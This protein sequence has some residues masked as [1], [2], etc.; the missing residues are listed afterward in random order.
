M[1]EKST[2]R[3]P[4]TPLH[5][6]N[7][8]GTA[9]RDA[10]QLRCVADDKTGDVCGRKHLRTGTT[11]AAEIRSLPPPPLPRVSLHLGQFC[12]ALWSELL[13]WRGEIASPQ[14]ARLIREQVPDFLS[15]LGGQR[16]RKPAPGKL[17]EQ[18]VQ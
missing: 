8:A 1:S 6:P 12:T 17:P 16:P 15:L 9:R 3:T 13:F 7:A 2:S 5:P 14:R 10:P 18:R 4:H 11:G